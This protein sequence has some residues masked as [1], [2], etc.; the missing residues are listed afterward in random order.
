ML[1]EKIKNTKDKNTHIKAMAND[2]TL[3]ANAFASSN[4]YF[5]NFICL[6]EVLKV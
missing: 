1:E 2:I 4:D 6:L 5:K 3:K